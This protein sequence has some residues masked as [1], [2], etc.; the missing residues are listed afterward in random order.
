MELNLRKF[1]TFEEIENESFEGISLFR[2]QSQPER[3]GVPS[4]DSYEELISFQNE[5]KVGDGTGRLF[6][7]EELDEQENFLLD[8]EKP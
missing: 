7:I 1:K 3:V 5:L 6:S 2:Y 8:E 4:L